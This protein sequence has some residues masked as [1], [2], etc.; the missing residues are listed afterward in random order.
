M[1]NGLNTSVNPETRQRPDFTET[2]KWF[3][4]GYSETRQRPDFSEIEKGFEHL[5]KPR[6][7]PETQFY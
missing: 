1:K 6:D 3:E 5:S 7:P 2:E 4:Q